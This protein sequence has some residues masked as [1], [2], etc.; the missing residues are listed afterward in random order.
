MIVS[1]RYNGNQGKASFALPLHS[2][3]HGSNLV[4]RSLVDVLK[5]SGNEIIMVVVSITHGTWDIAYCNQDSLRVRLL[6]P[7][8]GGGGN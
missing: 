6:E 8:G 3:N 2:E 4:P 7:N 5:R 1:V